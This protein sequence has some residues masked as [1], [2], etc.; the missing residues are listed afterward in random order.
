MKKILLLLLLFFGTAN[1]Q[2][3]LMQNGTFNTCSGT[4]YDSGGAGGDYTASQ[5]YQITFTPGIPGNY[6]QLS[7]SAFDLE[8]EPFDYMTIYQGVGTGGAVVGVFGVDSP[9]LCGTTIASNVPS[10]ALTIVFVS[11]GSLQFSG[12]EATISCTNVPG[13]P[14]AAPSNSTCAGADPFCADSGPLEFPNTPDSGCVPDAPA[15]ITANTCLITAPNPS[16]YYLSIGVPGNINLE[17]EQTTGPN[18]TGTGLDVD[19]AIWGPFTN[20][21]ATCADF[22]LG[23]CVGDHSCSGNVVDCS[24][25]PDPIETATIPGALVGQIYMVLITNFDGSPGYITM[26]QTNAGNASAG[27]TDCS[28]VCPTM[29]G[30]NPTTCSASDGAI[31]ISGLDPSTS[32]NITYFDDGNP[33]AVSLSSNASGIVTIAGLNAGNYTNIATNF[34][35]CTSAFANIVLTGA[36]A[37]VLTAVNNSTPICSGNNAV[38]TLTGTPNATVT[39]NINS[40]LSQTIV[41]NGAGTA[42]VTVN[43]VVANTTFNATAISLPGCSAALA[44]TRNVVVSPLATI[45]LNSAAATANQT[46]C[47]NAGITPISYT[48]GSGVT[49][50]MVSGLP[51]GVTGVYAAGIFTITGIPI[52]SGTFNYN[53]TTTGGCSSASL[54]GTIDV[55]PIATMVLGSA[56]ATTNQNVCINTGITAIFYTIAGGGTGATVLGLPAGVTG[57]F[58]AGVFTIS[59]IPTVSGSFNYTITTTGGCASVALG[60]TINVTADTTIALASA[61]ATTNQ[62]VCI[63]TPITGISYTIANGGTGATVSGLP[64]GVTGVFAAGVFTIGGTPTI[65]GIFNYTVTT[66]GGCSAAALGGTITISP[67]ASM[68]L[69]SAVSTTNQTLCISTPITAIVYIIGGGGTGATVSGLPTGVSGTYAAGTFTITGT[70]SI[71]GIFNYSVTTTGGC[72]SVTLGGT[73]TVNTDAT[74]A[75][76]SAIATTNQTICINTAI[77]PIGYTIA[78]G[79]TG[80]TVSGLPAG[81]TGVYAGGSFTLSGIPTVSGVF[82]YTITTTGGCS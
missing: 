69:N 50:A 80:A 12:W 51:T 37:P 53:V 25:S 56:V 20:A 2:T 24:W 10:G 22:T 5:N 16:W 29:A 42:T 73:I 30:T 26:T 3:Y 36:T 63:N 59:G 76:S 82:N 68:V 58:T 23:D 9:A 65:S 7:F 54:S 15:V 44:I 55:N 39:Y 19:Y 28:I 38:F 75:L 31:A 81:I 13:G 6:I 1:A 34:S 35:G 49:G 14:I 8:G 48:V 43:A 57:T 17:I 61:A 33:V 52:V 40:G 45:A 32:Y 66:T 27:T 70:P 21:A 78:T 11:D 72:A 46:I 60:G 18:G 67:M 4:F 71:S 62:T 74:I 79:G 77:I 64:T 47:I 41:L